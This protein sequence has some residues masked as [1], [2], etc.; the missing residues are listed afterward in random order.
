MDLDDL[1]L[2]ESASHAGSTSSV[3]SQMAKVRA[4][5][6]ALLARRKHAPKK[7]QLQI[8]QAQIQAQMQVQMQA[9]Q[10]QLQAQ[11]L[12]LQHE[13]ETADLDAEIDATVQREQVLKGELEEESHPPFGAVGPAPANVPLFSTPHSRAAGGPFYPAF[14]AGAYPSP[15]YTGLAATTIADQSGIVLLPPLANVFVNPSSSAAAVT[16]SA[17]SVSAPNF[18]PTTSVHATQPSAHVSASLGAIPRRAPASTA[19]AA[20]VSVTTSAPATAVS[21]AVTSTTTATSVA[22]STGSIPSVSVQPP[23][24]RRALPVSSAPVST[25]PYRLPPPLNPTPAPP[26]FMNNPQ[27]V[28]PPIYIQVPPQ[29]APAPQSNFDQIASLITSTTLPKAEILP[30]DSDPKN[31]TAFITNFKVPHRRQCFQPV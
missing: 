16:T 7:Q 18:V 25:A 4:D 31:Y 27:T 14:G 15:E 23:V 28:V 1:A 5:K 12:H 20:S 11:M 17:L 10:A 6:A 29:Q 8:Q 24:S 9:Q 22:V 26:P 3:R 13:T 21:V 2:G 30:F 19:T